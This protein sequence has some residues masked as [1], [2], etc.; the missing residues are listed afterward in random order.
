MIEIKGDRLPALPIIGLERVRDLEYYDGPLLS[1]FR[2]RRQGDHFLYYW[3][4]C[5]Q[6][7]NRWMLLRVSETNIIR[8]VTKF[9]PLDYVIPKSCQDDFVYFTDINH[10]GVTAQVVLSQLDNIPNDYFPAQGAYLDVEATKGTTQNKSYSLLIERS[11]S[12]G[13]LSDLPR[14]FSQAYALLYCL[15][16]L[17]PQNLA[18]YPWRGGFSAMHFY[19]WLL[20]LIPGEDRPDV[21]AVQYASPG[22]IRF[23]LDPIIAGHV[24]NIVAF[25][26]RG[27]Q[28]ANIAYTDLLTHIRRNK[29]NDVGINDSATWKLHN[30]ELT[31]LTRSLLSALQIPGLEDLMS[32]AP[33]PFEAAKIALSFMRRIRE[34]V[35]LEENGLVRF[36]FVR[37]SN[38]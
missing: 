37:N 1:H 2:H 25:L 34:L 19:R 35:E 7:S 5:D 12:I 23:S 3:C 6:T 33:R 30:A 4:D 11:L 28:E 14:H 32:A 13:N 26:L 31:V 9:V 22:F 15:L 8:L 21:A 17:K 29:L 20:D 16:V 38:T 18:G 36:P 10:Q 24:G 27:S